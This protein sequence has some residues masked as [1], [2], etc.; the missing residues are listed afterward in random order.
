M[1]N[2]CMICPINSTGYGM[3]SQGL[4]KALFS[5]PDVSVV[6]FP[7]GGNIQTTDLE[8]RD[9]IRANHFLEKK[10][11]R[12]FISIR[13]WHEFDQWEFPTDKRIA[14]PVWELD[15]VDPKRVGTQLSKMDA[16]FV[17]SRWQQHVLKSSTGLD[18]H[19]IPEGVNRKIFFSDESLKPSVKDE[20][21]FITIGKWEVRKNT[22]KIADAFYQAFEGDPDFR[23]TM[24]CGNP[25]FPPEE[26]QRKA[27]ALRLTDQ[28]QVRTN[29]LG[30]PYAVARALNTAHCGVFTSSAEGWCL[31]ALEALS[32]GLHLVASCNT[33]MTEFINEK[34][35]TIV[36]SKAMVPAQ[37]GWVFHG[38]GEWNLIETKDIAQAMKAKA[39]EL[40]E[41]E[42]TINQEGIKTAEAF[43][44]EKSAQKLVE[45]VRKL[46]L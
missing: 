19:V 40:T 31:P 14:Y 23:L 1:I 15:R 44:W 21:H 46:N 32:C 29:T 41:K 9:L 20:I 30:N 25:F 11:D 18:S 34:N 43:T 2:I 4:L 42:D 33:G 5:M 37:D 7:I 39:Q 10:W 3:H 26:M 16:V 45:T 6:V 17:P 12:D 24:Y 22:Q 8:L 38:Q 13:L 35:S 28:I 36:D 27:S